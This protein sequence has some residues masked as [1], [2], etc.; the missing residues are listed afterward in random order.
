VRDAR[1]TVA[2]VVSLMLGHFDAGSQG[3]LHTA[4]MRRADK[5]TGLMCAPPHTRMPKVAA[6]FSEDTH[7]WGERAHIG[8]YCSKTRTLLVHKAGTH[9]YTKCTSVREVPD[10][11]LLI[12]GVVPSAFLGTFF[13]ACCPCWAVFGSKFL[14]ALLRSE[15]ALP[16]RMFVSTPDAEAA[17]KACPDLCKCV[18]GSRTFVPEKH[19][20]AVAAACM[21]PDVV[22]VFN[23]GEKRRGVS[24]RFKRVRT[25]FGVASVEELG[26]ERPEKVWEAL[27][28]GVPDEV[29]STPVDRYSVALTSCCCQWVVAEQVKGWWE[30]APR[31]R[32]RCPLCNSPRCRTWQPFSGQPVPDRRDGEPLVDYVDR[33]P[34]GCSEREIVSRLGKDCAVRAEADDVPALL[35]SAYGRTD[36]LVVMS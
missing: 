2:K 34:D 9:M 23:A 25:D 21:P 18:T 11:V 20:V 15:A 22:E 32:G 27:Q 29:M 24:L 6:V 35:R 4:N 36:V 28:A 1:S 13:D 14:K 7:F 19:A 33:I 16:A 8:V 31:C 5:V 3:W 17:V 26:P 30:S 10:G 12:S